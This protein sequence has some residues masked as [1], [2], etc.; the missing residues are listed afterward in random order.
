M[1]KK[2]IKKIIPSRMLSVMI[3][4]KLGLSLLN[5]YIYDYRI[6]RAYNGAKLKMNTAQI[7]GKIIA[8]YHTLEKGI[9]HIDPKNCFSLPVAQNLVKLINLYDKKVLYAVDKLM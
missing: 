1:I 9:S 5:Q 3:N 2:L 6:Y 7:E 4:F 8:H